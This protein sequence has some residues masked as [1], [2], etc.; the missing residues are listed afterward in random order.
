MPSTGAFVVT[1]VEKRD[2][3]EVERRMQFANAALA[4][5]GHEVTDPKLR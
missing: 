4:L 1:K 5:A 2:A 3:I